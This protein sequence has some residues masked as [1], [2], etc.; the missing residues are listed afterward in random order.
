[1][2]AAVREKADVL[3]RAKRRLGDGPGADAAIE[4]LP[5]DLG[6]KVRGVATG[7]DV[8]PDRDTQT[9]QILSSPPPNQESAGLADDPGGKPPPAGVN[10]SHHSFSRPGKKDGDAV[11][12]K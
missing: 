6:G 1:M 7:A 9:P 3:H 12:D 10:G 4:K 2:I 8:R 11:G 5:F